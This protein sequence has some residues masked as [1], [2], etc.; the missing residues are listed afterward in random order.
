MCFGLVWAG[1]GWTEAY[2]G[3]GLFVW[4]RGDAI[5]DGSSVDGCRLSHGG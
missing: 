1:V 2:L 3:T 4:R 5:L